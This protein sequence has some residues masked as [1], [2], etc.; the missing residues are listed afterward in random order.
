MRSG[1]KIA[2]PGTQCFVAD[3]PWQYRRDLTAALGTEFPASSGIR[4][5]ELSDQQ[6]EDL[7]FLVAERG[8]VIFREQGDLTMAKQVQ[9]GKRFGPLHVHPMGCADPD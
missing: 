9:L 1:T 6:V 4:L 3:H 5:A 8:V 2:L 7:A